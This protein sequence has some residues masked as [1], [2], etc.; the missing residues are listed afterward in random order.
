MHGPLILLSFMR[1]YLESVVF[2]NLVGQWDGVLHLEPFSDH[3]AR[4]KNGLGFQESIQFGGNIF[5]T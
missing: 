4:W 1:T 2:E 5:Q 3:S